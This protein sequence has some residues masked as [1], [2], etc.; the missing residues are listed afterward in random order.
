MVTLEDDAE[1]LSEHS[2]F[3]K[4]QVLK[5]YSINE[6]L[7]SRHSVRPATMAPYTSQLQHNPFSRNERC[8]KSFPPD[9]RF[10]KKEQEFQP[11]PQQ[12]FKLAQPAPNGAHHPTNFQ[13]TPFE[14][15]NGID[16]NEMYNLFCFNPVHLFSLLV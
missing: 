1:D 11:L 13:T 3:S 12:F 4:Q 5:N 2:N 6:Y 7:H 9:L 10:L 16:C 14:K 8:R 15:V